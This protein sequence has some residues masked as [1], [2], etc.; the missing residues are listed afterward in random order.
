MNGYAK[1][2]DRKNKYINLL[3]HDKELLKKIQCNMG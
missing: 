3:L 1:Y 2:F